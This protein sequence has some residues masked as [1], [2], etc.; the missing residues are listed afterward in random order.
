MKQIAQI[1]NPFKGISVPSSGG[2][3]QN[4]NTATIG[5]I[6]TSLL[7]YVFSA[8]AIILLIYL[9]LAGLQLMTSRGDP[10]AVQ[11]AQAK[12]TTSLI[13]FVIVFMAYALVRLLGQILGISV[14]SV[15]FQ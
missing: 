14:F 10:K 8:T 15:I 13:G 9:V 11:V 5:E 4:V 3:I 2:N 6:I 1:P 12:I 7:T